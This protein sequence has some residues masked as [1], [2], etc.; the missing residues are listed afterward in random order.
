MHTGVKYLL[1]GNDASCN[2][3]A[4]TTRSEV[5]ADID[6]ATTLHTCIRLTGNT[7]QEYAITK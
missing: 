1:I 5:R 7:A 2:V 6:F 3:S 4:N